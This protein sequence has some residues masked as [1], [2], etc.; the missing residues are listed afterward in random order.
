MFFEDFFWTTEGAEGAERGRNSW[1]DWQGNY[2]I[3]KCCD[4]SQNL[5][6]PWLSVSPI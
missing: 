4:E 6:T 5:A 2:F 3:H 1:R